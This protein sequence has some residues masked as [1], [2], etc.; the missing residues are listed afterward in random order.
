[1]SIGR[2]LSAARCF[3]EKG[4]CEPTRRDVTVLATLD[5]PREPTDA[6]G[7]FGSGHLSAHR[8]IMHMWLAAPNIAEVPKVSE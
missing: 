5:M 2:D 4:C 7:L 3:R 1:M 6:L 8:S